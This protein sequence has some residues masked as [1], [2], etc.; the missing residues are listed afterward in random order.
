MA[1]YYKAVQEEFYFE[2]MLIE[3]AMIEDRTL[4]FLYHCGIQNSRDD[5]KISKVAKKE[6]LTIILPSDNNKERRFSLNGLGNKLEIIN[7]L[8]TWVNESGDV[9]DNKYLKVLKSQLEGVD[10][11]LFQEEMVN[12]AKWK[13]YRNEVM[14]AL[15]NKNMIS[16][17]D[18]LLNEV[19][20]GMRLARF[21]D[22]QVRIIKKNNRIRRAARLA[23]NG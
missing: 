3:Y 12:V 6:L 20:E 11:Q 10:I 23:V 16:L 18:D 9:S 8:V 22:C 13:N 14:H 19:M 5:L 15:L 4:S 17:K 21:I 7:A 2:A 1:P